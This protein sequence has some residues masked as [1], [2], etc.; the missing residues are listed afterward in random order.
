MVLAVSCSYGQQDVEQ[1]RIEELLEVNVRGLIVFPTDGPHYNESLL[2]LY[3]ERFPTVVVDKQLPGVPFPCVVSDNYGGAKQLTNHLLDLG[4]KRIAFVTLPMDGTST[5]LD[6]WRGFED[7]IRESNV[8]EVREDRLDTLHPPFNENTYNQ[9]QLDRLVT[10]I[11]EHPEITAIFSTRYEIAQHMFQAAFQVGKT[12][13]DDLSMVCFDGIS[14]M[15]SH[16]QFTHVAQDGVTVA[17]EATRL[18]LEVMENPSDEGEQVIVPTRFYEGSS[19]RK[20]PLTPQ[21]HPM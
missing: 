2:R 11:H 4:H 13:P 9:K 7:A 6:R 10:F 17:A 14:L 8:A 3:V 15:P 21:P 20:L 18:L 16:W 5:L 1:R 12:I 19:T